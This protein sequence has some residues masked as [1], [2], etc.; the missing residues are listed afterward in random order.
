MDRFIDSI[1]VY[2]VHLFVSFFLRKIVTNI[3]T[4]DRNK[5]VLIAQRYRQQFSFLR[6]S[7][8]F[9]SISCWLAAPPNTPFTV[10]NFYC[11]SNRATHNLSYSF[12]T[13]EESCQKNGKEELLRSWN[14]QCGT[15]TCWKVSSSNHILVGSYLA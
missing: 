4:Y 14:P 12:S 11:S 10:R 13:S 8:F 9:R 7:S 6:V 1:W 15:Q 3:V 5:H 2:R